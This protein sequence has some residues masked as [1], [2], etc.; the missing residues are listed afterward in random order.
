M[1]YDPW[2]Q[3]APLLPFA[4]FVVAVWC[5][6]AG[7]LVALP[8]MVVAGSYALQTHLSYSLLVPGLAGFALVAVRG[9]RRPATPP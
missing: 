2:S 8:I 7:D 1:L 4:L 6:V 3:Y 5:A 9:E